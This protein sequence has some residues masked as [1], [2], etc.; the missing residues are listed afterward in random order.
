MV[1]D[2]QVTTTSAAGRQPLQQS[3][4]LT[5]SATGLLGAGTTVAGQPRLVH[6]KNGPVDKTGVMIR[7]QD[8]PLFAR[9]KPY[10]FAYAP[11][12]IDVAFGATF[13]IR[14]GSCIDRVAQDGMN[15]DV[16]RLDPEDLSIGALVRK[17]QAFR[18]K[19]KPHLTSRPQ[20]SELFKNGADS[21][22]HGL[23]WMKNDLPSAFS[24]EK[25]NG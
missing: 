4:T 7:H 18:L 12:F 13:T 5:N 17:Q 9:Q 2:P 21:A 14:I 1:V 6:F 24:P 11:G 8:C 16:G 20:F 23:I 3:R 22:G 19:P 10:S 15:G 25:T